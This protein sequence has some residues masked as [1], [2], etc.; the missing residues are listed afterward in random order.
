MYQLNPHNKEL[1]VCCAWVFFAHLHHLSGFSHH[2]GLLAGGPKGLHRS[3]ALWTM[4]FCLGGLGVFEQVL[5]PELPPP[6]S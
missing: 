5:K 3:I 4:K 1:R 2:S 6:A